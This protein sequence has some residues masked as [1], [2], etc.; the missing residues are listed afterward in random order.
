M[1]TIKPTPGDLIGQKNAENAKAKI[2]IAAIWALSF[3]LGG[4][5]ALI[6]QSIVRVCFDID[7]DK[8]CHSDGDIPLQGYKLKLNGANVETG[9]DGTVTSTKREMYVIFN[10]EQ[11][12][13]LLMSGKTPTTFCELGGSVRVGP[14]NNGQSELNIVLDQKC[15]ESGNIPKNRSRNNES[16][17]QTPYRV[18]AAVAKLNFRQ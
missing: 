9:I 1:E 2:K 11:P 4:D 8:Y 17:H 15:A 12:T 6:P 14:N 3:V 7:Q 10:Q 5:I 18:Q 13:T 16:A